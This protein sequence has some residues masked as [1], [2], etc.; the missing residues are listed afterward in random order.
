MDCKYCERRKDKVQGTKLFKKELFDEKDGK[1]KRVVKEVEQHYDDEGVEGTFVPLGEFAV[2]RNLQHLGF[3]E[4][5][6][7]A[8]LVLKMRVVQNRHDDWG[9]EI[10]DLNEGSYRFRRGLRE[11]AEKSKEEV[12]VSKAKDSNF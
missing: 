1:K 11:V 2:Q 7:H 12:Q 8:Q 6:D 4:L 10:M 5:I 3:H 9:V